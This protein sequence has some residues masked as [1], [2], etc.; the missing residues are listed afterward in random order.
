MYTVSFSSR[1]ACIEMHGNVSKMCSSHATAY[2][3]LQ[4]TILTCINEAHKDKI[5]IAKCKITFGDD[6][7]VVEGRKHH[8]YIN[9]K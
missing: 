1:G 7:L 6:I 5:V 9:K 4:T 2:T 3:N 8:E